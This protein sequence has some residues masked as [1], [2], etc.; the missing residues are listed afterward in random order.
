MK[1]IHTSLLFVFLLVITTHTH[2]SDRFGKLTSDNNFINSDQESLNRGNCTQEECT[3]GTMAFTLSAVMG[4]AI[5]FPLCAA[6]GVSAGIPFLA[7]LGSGFTGTMLYMC[8]HCHKTDNS[9]EI[10]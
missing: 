8:C 1:H 3:D 6:L 10:P 2:G 4:G 7:T 5:A 9:P